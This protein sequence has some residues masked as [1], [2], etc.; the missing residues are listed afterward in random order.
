MDRFCICEIGWTTAP[1]WTGRPDT[2][3]SWA[4]IRLPGITKQSTQLRQRLRV[5]PHVAPPR[6][7]TTAQLSR[8]LLRLRLALSDVSLPQ[9]HTWL[10]KDQEAGFLRPPGSLTLGG[11]HPRDDLHESAVQPPG[12]TRRSTA[13]QRP[14]RTLP[15]P[16]RLLDI[17]GYRS[18]RSRAGSITALPAFPRALP[19]RV[20]RAGHRDGLPPP[21][22]P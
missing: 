10:H 6:P 19:F 8:I 7:E 3:A 17:L 21:S 15:P 16:P 12:S 5:A 11:C 9:A 18:G 20:G 1:W 22:S 4:L 14:G 2:W 13:P